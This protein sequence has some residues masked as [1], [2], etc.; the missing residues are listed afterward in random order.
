MKA[1]LEK[2]SEIE[3]E[4]CKDDLVFKYLSSKMQYKYNPKNIKSTNRKILELC[5]TPN[6]VS[7]DAIIIY[8][9]EHDEKGVSDYLINTMNMNSD[10]LDKSFFYLNQLT[11]MLTYKKYKYPI[12]QYIIDKGI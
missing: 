1:N 4:I 12:E 8:L 6:L 10:I 7:I 11:T 5:E 2:I 3:D 9:N